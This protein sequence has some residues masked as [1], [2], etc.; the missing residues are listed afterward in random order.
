[1]SAMLRLTPEQL[2][3][4]IDRMAKSLPVRKVRKLDAHAPVVGGEAAVRANQAWVKPKAR[5]KGEEGLEMALRAA[6]APAWVCEY[7]FMP[8]RRYRADFC[9]LEACLLVEVEGGSW[10]RG[11]HTRGKGFEEDCEKYA[12]AVCRGYRVL[13]VTTAMVEDGRA[14]GYIIRALTISPETA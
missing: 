6:N 2:K 8:E 3:A 1:M 10:S 5:S 12:E 11:R 13:R 9:F 7:R 4:H 14:L